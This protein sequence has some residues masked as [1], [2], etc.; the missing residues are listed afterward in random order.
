MGEKVANWASAIM[1]VMALLLF[2][3]NL[4]LI[5]GN[6]GRQE[7]INQRQEAINRGAA[8]QQLTANLSQALAQIAIKNNDDRVR[9]LLCAEYAPDCADVDRKL[10]ANERSKDAQKKPVR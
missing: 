6:R 4:Y 10:K 9:E 1:G 3:A 7:E 8:M 2:G 5:E